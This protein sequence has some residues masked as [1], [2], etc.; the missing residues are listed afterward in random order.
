MTSLP[1]QFL[2]IHSTSAQD[3][4]PSKLLSAQRAVSIMPPPVV[5][6]MY[7]L[8]LLKVLRLALST[9]SDQLGFVK[10]SKALR[11]VSRG[12]T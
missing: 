10:M 11:A 7:S 12:G 2:R 4:E 5:F 6:L 9:L 1:C 3:S 8:M